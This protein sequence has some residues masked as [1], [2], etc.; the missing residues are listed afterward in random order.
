MII[1]KT[2]SKNDLIDLINN[3]N[4]NI[5]F[6]FQ[7]NKKSIQDKLLSYI[8]KGS[9]DIQKNYYNITYIIFRVYKNNK[10]M[11]VIVYDNTQDTFKNRFNRFNKSS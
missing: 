7:D 3:L 5:V 10:K 1:H 8:L 4:L 11:Y 6:S 2:H 9:I